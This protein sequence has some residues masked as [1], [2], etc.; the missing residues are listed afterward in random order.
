MA[1]SQDHISTSTPMVATLTDGGATFR[2][3]GPGALHVYA[4]F[5]GGGQAPSPSDELVK[6]PATGH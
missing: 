4:T 1:A 2:A 6:D 5:D 3:W